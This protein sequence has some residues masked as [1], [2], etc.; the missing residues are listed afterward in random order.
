MTG[1]ALKFSIVEPDNYL[2][3]FIDSI[4]HEVNPNFNGI[5]SDQPP[6]K[7]NKLIKR[8]GF[9]LFLKTAIN[10]QKTSLFPNN[11]VL[12]D[13]VKMSALRTYQNWFRWENHGFTSEIKGAKASMGGRMIRFLA[14]EGTPPTFL[15]NFGGQGICGLCFSP[16]QIIY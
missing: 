16:T 7:L 8:L 9:W 2:H 4:P 14:K 6:V 12:G 15:Q 3:N 10:T 13:I 5:Y 11:I 1:Q